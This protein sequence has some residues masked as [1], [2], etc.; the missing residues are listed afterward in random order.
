MNELTLCLIVVA[1]ALFLIG[2]GYGRW[3]AKRERGQ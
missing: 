2:W 3:I 1:A